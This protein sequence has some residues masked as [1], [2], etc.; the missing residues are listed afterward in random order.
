ME[1]FDSTPP[2]HRPRLVIKFADDVELNLP[3]N[4]RVGNAASDIPWQELLGRFPEAR[5]EPLFGEFGEHTLRSLRERTA[6]A[7]GSSAPDLRSFVAVSFPPGADPTES[8]SLVEAWQA[9]ELAYVEAAPAPPP[10]DAS[11]D[12]RRSSQGHLNPAPVGVDAETAW[13]FPGGDG[14]GV[15]FVDLEQGWTLNHED[16]SAA[17]ITLISGRNQAFD[18]HGTAVLGVVVGQDNT[19]GGLGIAPACSARVVSEWRDPTTFSTPAAIISAALAMEPG[20]VLLL[21]A[22]RR[23]GGAFL[24]I[25]VEFA[26][27][28]AILVATALGIVVVEA[29]GNGPTDLDSHS[30]PRFGFIFRRGH[31]DFRDSGAIMVGACS[32]ATPRSRR[33]SSNFGSRID[34]HAWGQNI[35]TT[36]GSAGTT[37]TYR[38]N[39]SGTSGASAIVA[40]VAVSVQGM[41]ASRFGSR[42]DP[43]RMRTILSRSA[44]G[45]ASSAPAADKVG[46]MPSLRKI[47]FRELEPRGDFPLPE[48]DT[49][50]AAARRRPRVVIDPGHGGETS[51]GGSTPYGCVWNDGDL[52]KDRNLCIARQMASN[53]R[54]W[55]P[56]VLTRDRDESLSVRERVTT[57][58]RAHADVFVSAHGHARANGET[59]VFVHDNAADQSQRLGHSVSSSL[60]LAVPASV[61]P[62]PLSVLEPRAHPQRTAACM[63]EVADAASDRAASDDIEHV[64]GAMAGGILDYLGVRRDRWGGRRVWGDPQ[65]G[66]YLPDGGREFVPT[67]ATLN[68]AADD[69][70][71]LPASRL[72]VSSDQPDAVL[73]SVLGSLELAKKQIRRVHKSGLVPFARLFGPD[74]L[75]ELMQRLRWSAKWIEKWGRDDDDMLVPRLLLH[76]PGHFRELA[77]RAPNEVEAHAL[78]SIG[79]LLMATLRTEVEQATGNRFWIPPAPQF[80]SHFSDTLPDLS[81]QVEALLLGRALIDTRLS[82]G[83]V[84]AYQEAW[85]RSLA[86]RHWREETSGADPGK[87]FYPDLV[88]IPAF[89]DVAAQRTI[90]ENAWAQR[91]ADVDT[92]FPPS[93]GEITL[94]ALQN[95]KKLRSD[96]GSSAYLPSGT[97]ERLDPGGLH[98][99]YDFPNE[100]TPSARKPKVLAAL[101]PAFNAIFSTLRELGWND[102]VYQTSG[103]G[104][105]RGMKSGHKVKLLLPDGSDDSISALSSP[106][107]AKVDKI[108]AYGDDDGKERV[109]KAIRRSRKM[110][111]HAMGIAIDINVPENGQNVEGRKYGSI[112][113]RVVALFEA[114]NFKWGACFGDTDP[115]HF[116]YCK[117]DCAP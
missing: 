69:F 102:L 109:L 99:V 43:A 105:F 11:D 2:P 45:V 31:R 64:A 61:R 40:G 60:A 89:T 5:V 83:D 26:T 65:P 30:D 48:G 13:S 90:F 117:D 39:F 34:C 32:S 49:R 108:N 115:H 38:N 10:I 55:V 98:L 59:C 96:D 24:P 104:V 15:G 72:P 103:A 94:T 46:P 73:E 22:Q 41:A 84:V 58:R 78:E 17:A 54:P 21:E 67:A 71:V 33:P 75:L 113:P 27:Y 9:A 8:V 114:F 1:S 91:V 66:L 52:E 80:V 51:R 47:I 28:V 101:L 29:A 56:V 23:V 12:P 50:Y 93:P 63:V 87:P 74:A 25:E 20:D 19:K 110:S 97:R 18:G 42:F 81:P 112:D 37:T 7:S 100:G 85:S 35:N 111:D 53:L 77:R 88:T 6:Q 79:W 107:Q 16:L 68:C 14:A 57:T 44:N 70:R 62:A 95:A 116:E 4:A 82:F 86:G 3:R 106:T 92:E 76:V 36:D